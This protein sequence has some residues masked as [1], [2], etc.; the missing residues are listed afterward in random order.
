MNFELAG[1]GSDAANPSAL[2]SDEADVAMSIR[3]AFSRASVVRGPRLRPFS[4][5]AIAASA[6]AASRPPDRDFFSSEFAMAQ[7]KFRFFSIEVTELKRRGAD[8]WTGCS[9]FDACPE[10]AVVL[11]QRGCLAIDLAF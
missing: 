5:S 4:P 7:S 8:R 2:N 9:R 3:L 1:R 11:G 10:T 6:G